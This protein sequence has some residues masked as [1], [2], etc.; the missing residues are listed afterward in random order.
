MPSIKKRVTG[1]IRQL[2]A[3]NAAAVAAQSEPQP[4]AKQRASKAT[5]RASC[6]ADSGRYGFIQRYLQSGESHASGPA[7]MSGKTGHDLPVLRLALPL[8]EEVFAA[9]TGPEGGITALVNDEEEEGQ[10]GRQR[11]LVPP[12][13][14]CEDFDFIDL[15]EGTSKSRRGSKAD[16]E[17]NVFCNGW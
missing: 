12:A 13:E 4:T 6:Q 7:I 2:S 11:R 10:N 14:D 3:P 15:E 17:E 1:F 9:F 5:R 16:E 8:N